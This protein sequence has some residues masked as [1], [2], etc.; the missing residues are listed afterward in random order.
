MKNMKIKNSITGLLLLVVFT[1]C[2]NLNYQ[3]VTTKDE[4]WMYE[5]PL[6]GIQKLVDDLY[7][8]VQYDFGTYSGA[9]LASASDESDYARLLSDVHKYY[10]GGLSSFSPIVNPTWTNSYQAIAQAN[11]FLEKLDKISLDEYLYNRA[12]QTGYEYLKEKFEMFPYEVRF[13][14]AYF[15]FELAKTYGDVPLVTKTL[16]NSEANSVTRTPVQEVFKYIV[17]E[18][19]AIAEHLPISHIDTRAQQT[20]RASRPMALALKARTLLYAASPLFNTNNDKELWRQAAAAGKAVIDRAAGWGIILGDYSALWG[21]DNH[22]NAE[23]IFIRRT[24]SNNFFEQYN[25][26]IGVENGNSG[27]CPTQNLVDAYEYQ[28]NGKTWRELEAAG[29]LPAN[30]YEGLDPRFE[31]TVVKN[32]D[33]WPNYETALI[34]TFEGGRNASPLL[35]ATPTGYYLKKYA[36]GSADIRTNNPTTKYHT[37]IIFRLS[38]LYLNYAEAVYNYLGSADAKSAEFTLSANEAINVLRD[39]ADIQMPHFTGNANFV[40]RYQRERMVELAFEDHRFWDVRRWKKGAEFFT[41][42]YSMKLTK[43]GNNIVY[44]RQSKNRLWNE[45]NNFYPIPFAE[46]KI[47]PNLTQNPG[48]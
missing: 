18:C 38:E 17:D 12:G 35:N 41:Q 15:F 39:R 21:N 1:A 20:G 29:Q 28:A 32:G 33:K 19:D 25:F 11:E 31:L 7:A 8:H 45:R 13:L 10:D 30:P 9:M 44:T 37:W 22:R 3:E 36:D 46:T 43:S 5:S 4:T 27:N 6:Y 40:E 16:S 26:P 24:G 14:R 48:W 47:N 23:M 34:E 42:I 2:D